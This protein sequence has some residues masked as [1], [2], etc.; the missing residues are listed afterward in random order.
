MRLYFLIIIAVIALS[1]AVISV[2]HAPGMELISR[3]DGEFVP[4]LPPHPHALKAFYKKHCMKP[5]QL[6]FRT[7]APYTIT[8]K[9]GAGIHKLTVPA[10]YV[11][12]GVSA[13]IRNLPILGEHEDAYWL[14][15]DYMYQSQQFDDGT[16]ITKRQ[17]DNIMH[18][19]IMYNKN[20]PIWCRLY[21]L[22]V[23]GNYNEQYWKAI[24]HRGP[25]LYVCPGVL[26]FP[27]IGE[28]LIY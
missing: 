22:F 28:Y 11:T 7:I 9:I 21:R 15:H 27:R 6:R 17:A 4:L 18:H 13:P 20:A 5:I 19:V 2:Y 10:N 26:L 25:C 1:A 3:T 12:D 23:N 16:P 8:V 14:Y 24:Y